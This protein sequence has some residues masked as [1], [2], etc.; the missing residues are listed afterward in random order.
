MQNPY[1]CKVRGNNT[2]IEVFSIVC[3]FLDVMTGHLKL[4][5]THVS[6][7]SH[8]EMFKVFFQMILLVVIGRMMMFIEV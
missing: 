2:R 8:L 5:L 3:Q 1:S 7:V 6:C 4:I